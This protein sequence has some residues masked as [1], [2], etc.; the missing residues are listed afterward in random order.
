MK[1]IR[2]SDN[3]DDRCDDA[4]YDDNEDVDDDDYDDDND[5]RTLEQNKEQTTNAL[6]IYI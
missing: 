5:T 6:N 2:D 4:D 3:A 1:H